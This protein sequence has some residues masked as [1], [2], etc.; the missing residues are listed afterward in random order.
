MIAILVAKWIA[1]A[2]E[3]EG[4]YDLAQTIIG[5]PFLD[6]DQSTAIAQRSGEL[7]SALIPPVQTMAEI[8]VSLPIDGRVPYQLL[9]E[10]LN[11]LKRR[12]LADAGLVL[13]SNGIFRGYLPQGELDFGLNQLGP[14]IPNLKPNTN[15]ALIHQ[16]EDDELDLSHFVDRTPLTLYETAPIEYAVEMFGKLGLRYLVV[17]QEVTGKVVGIVIKKRLVLWLE[18][19]K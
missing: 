8:T 2:L 14:T 15:V 4:V 6:I 9:E 12:G 7:T 1:D 13:V 18:E 19:R 16:A 10:K 5:H 3:K 17:L 11:L